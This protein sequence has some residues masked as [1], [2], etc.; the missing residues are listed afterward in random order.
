MRAIIIQLLLV[1][2]FSNCKGQTTFGE[3]K[4]KLEKTI[5][6]PE[7]KGRIDHMAFNLK[8]K[9]LYMAALGNNTVEVI[10]LQKGA[11]IQS[12]KGVEEPQGIAY[13]PE[14]NE[15]AVASGGNG[16]C[17]FFDASTF[18]K[19]ATVHL[20]GDADNI[21]YD[22]A[23][24]KIYVGYGNGGMALI[25]PVSHKQT[26]DVKL[27]AHP[28]SF[29]LDK[30]NNKLYV[31]LPD[32]HSISVINL[33]TFKLADTWKIAR[34]RANFPMTLDTANNLV[35]IGYRHPAVL[36]WYD[37]QTGEEIG[38]VDLAGDVDDIFYNAGKQMVFAS[39]GDGFINLFGRE[40]RLT[41]NKVANIRTRTG[42]RTSLLIPQ[43]QEWVVAARATTGKSAALLVYSLQP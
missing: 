9:V 15:V 2:C 37:S 10:D 31:N 26:R 14:Q 22:A 20:A 7:V 28:E 30:K 6:M 29:Q 40:D 13:I 16:D 23:E 36:A 25:D 8:D 32:D 33:K 41:F 38:K 24:R 27:A 34:L 3:D 12:I 4:L 43:L 1:I 19:V 39:C 5:E 21:R 17:V 35:F 11:V 42:A 18:K